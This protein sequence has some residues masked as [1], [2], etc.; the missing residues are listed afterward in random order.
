MTIE[1][2]S[3]T[4]ETFDRDIYSNHRLNA[5]HTLAM[6]A[7]YLFIIPETITQA[8]IEK[9]KMVDDKLIDLFTK[10]TE[11]IITYDD[12]LKLDIEENTP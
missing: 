11:R 1:G 4:P 6:I 10:I 2:A 7:Q 9:I 5:N 3:F 12:A 8:D